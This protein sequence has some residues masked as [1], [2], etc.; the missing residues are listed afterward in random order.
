[1]FADNNLA[2]PTL[3]ELANGSHQDCELPDLEEDVTAH[4]SR[5][6]GGKEGKGKP[7][8]KVGFNIDVAQK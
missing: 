7:S 2:L 8:K 4:K 6:K 3:T 1:M 5:S